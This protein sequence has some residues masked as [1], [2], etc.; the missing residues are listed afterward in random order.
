[1]GDGSHVV[2]GKKFPDERLSV[3]RCVCD[4]RASSFVAKFRCEVFAHIYPVPVKGHSSMR[5]WL[6]GLPG[7][8]LCGKWWT[9][10]W[11]C[12]SSVSHFCLIIARFSVALFPIFA[13]NLMHTRCQD[14]REI[15][16]GQ[17]HD[18]R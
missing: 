12:S 15:A 3:R 16:S 17:I 10:S 8:I 2:F 7:R 13:Q 4:A 14:H 11:L 18:S 1:V 9:C 6:L 5:N